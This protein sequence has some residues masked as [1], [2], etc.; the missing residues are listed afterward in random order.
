MKNY[1]NTI[2]NSSKKY[3]TTN[4]L[5]MTFI[6]TNLINVTMLRFMTV[7]NYFN[8]KPLIAD[9]AAIIIIGALAYFLKP[10]NQFK[11]F[12]AWSILFTIIITIN[13]LYYTNYISFASVSLLA[14]SLQITDVGDA[15]VEN[16]LQ[17]KD[18]TYLW[19]VPVLIFV[20]INLKKKDYYNF[21][22]TIEKGKVRAL[23]TLVA[24]LIFAGFFS[25]M[26]TSLDIA[27]LGKQWN[28]EFIVM[29]FGLLTYQAN[30]IISSLRPQFSTLFGYDEKAK[31]FREFYATYD[32]NYTDNRYSNA[33]KGKNVIAIHAESIQSF[34]IEK[35]MNGL[36]VTPNLNKLVKDGLYFSNFYSQ[37][38]VGT[39][40]DTEF[41]FNTSLLPTS[42][43]TVFINYFD[44]EYISI[45]NLLRE[46]GYSTFSMHG[47]NGDFWN[48]RTMHPSLGYDHFYNYTTDY[49]IDEVIGL[50]L[51]DK[52]FFRQSVPIISKVNEKSQNFYGLLIMLTNHT[53]FS[54][55][56]KKGMVEFPV[57]MDYEAIDPE[58]GETTINTASYLEGTKMGNYIKSVHYAD[59][60]IGEFIA[61]LDEAGLLENTAIV[62]YG[63]HDAKLRA[64]E[65]DRYYNYDPATD[66]ILSKEDP[67]YIPVDFFQYELDRKVPFIIW[68]KDGS[69]KGRGDK[70]MG[71][72]DAMPTLGNMLGVH[73]KYALGHDYFSHDDNVVVFPDGN[74]ITDIMYYNAQKQEGKLFNLDA[75]INEEY[76]RLNNEYAEKALEISSST[77]LYDLIKRAN[78]TVSLIKE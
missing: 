16:V 61:G 48:R 70:V 69:V 23:N 1:F 55:I 73:N 20:H 26:L 11:Y 54:D 3:I 36:E 77:I 14:T 7:N 22:Q 46:E 63:D 33:L 8:I 43:G 75:T 57:T 59:A 38:G 6:T 76:I 4:I 31:A 44:R 9:L 68:T 67:N 45:P 17:I 42:S 56:V 65:W 19:Q 37:E 5:F 49:Q 2:K 27:R 50:G 39:S 15:V 35:E 12:L 40:S 64:S 32:N 28:R 34:L 25:S 41:T 74:W 18:F 24:G 51:S 13:S 53:P 72:Y 10:K 52:S 21:V 78:E 60:A 71:M 30:D 66:S 58:T 62:I 29:Q 47:N